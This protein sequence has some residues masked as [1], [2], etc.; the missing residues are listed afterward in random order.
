M[1]VL[2]VIAVYQIKQLVLG[3]SEYVLEIFFKLLF[4]LNRFR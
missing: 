3:H 1:R 4:E 2:L